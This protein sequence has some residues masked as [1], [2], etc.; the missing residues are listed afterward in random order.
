[1][2]LSFICE[3]AYTTFLLRSE[4]AGPKIPCSLP[5]SGKLG[6]GPWLMAFPLY[7][8]IEH[9]NNIDYIRAFGVK[10]VK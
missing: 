3:D 9:A 8:S 5:V 10:Y 2:K 1:M 6:L 4:D 7:C